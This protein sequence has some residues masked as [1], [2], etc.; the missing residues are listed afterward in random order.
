MPYRASPCPEQLPGPVPRTSGRGLCDE[1]WC[2]CNCP[3]TSLSAHAG[4]SFRQK[5]RCVICVDQRV[6]CCDAGKPRKQG[7]GFS[8]GSSGTKS[9]RPGCRD[10]PRPRGQLFAARRSPGC[11]S[12]ASFLSARQARMTSVPS[13]IAEPGSGHIGLSISDP[14]ASDQGA[15][16]RSLIS[17]KRTAVVP[18]YPKPNIAVIS[19]VSIHGGQYG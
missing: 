17:L 12:G 11:L 10:V 13:E 15:A 18:L 8:R 19:L 16:W 6:G 2:R 7:R 14:K 3:F 1:P 4:D 5:R 9:R